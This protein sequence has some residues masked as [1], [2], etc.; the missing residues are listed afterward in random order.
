MVPER[1]GFDGQILLPER[2]IQFLY[3][4][5]K[6][7]WI[8]LIF[9]TPTVG[10]LVKRKTWRLVHRCQLGQRFRGE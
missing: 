3:K 8:L 4:I 6:A 2:C 5:A 1:P 7:D 9:R 10:R